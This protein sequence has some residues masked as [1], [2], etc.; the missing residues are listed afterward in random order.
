[1]KLLSNKEERIV[2]FFYASGKLDR[3]GLA[4]KFSV[5]IEEVDRALDG[6]PVRKRQA[7]AREAASQAR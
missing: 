3:Y 4:H 7:Q 1:M 5:C 6:R 2:Q